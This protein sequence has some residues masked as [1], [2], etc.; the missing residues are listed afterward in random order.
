MTHVIL[1]SAHELAN[2]RAHLHNIQ[3]NVLLTYIAPLC[4]TWWFRCLVFTAGI[5]ENAQEVRKFV[6][7]LECWHQIT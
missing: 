2:K 6:I 1:L 5:G 7:D 3:A 4:F